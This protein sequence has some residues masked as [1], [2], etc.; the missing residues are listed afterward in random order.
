M[1]ILGTEGTSSLGCLLSVL[2]PKK[3]TQQINNKITQNL[4]LIGRASC[5]ERV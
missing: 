1:S 3:F 4:S 2:H 5:R